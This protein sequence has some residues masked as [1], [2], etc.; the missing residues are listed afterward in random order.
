LPPTVYVYASVDVSPERRHG[1]LGSAKVSSMNSHQ[2]R[3]A[4]IASHAC[5][6]LSPTRP[7]LC[8]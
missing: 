6:L 5:R 8:P 2:S 3:A 1:A 7:T 4:F